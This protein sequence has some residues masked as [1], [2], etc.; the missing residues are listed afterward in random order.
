MAELATLRSS[1]R[2]VG[3]EY[4]IYKN[5]LVRFAA[6][7]LGLDIEELLTGPT[8]IALVG[9]RPDGTPATRS[10]WPRRCASSPATTTSW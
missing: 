7:E 5:T 1:L 9:D 8:A 10:G 2:E 3:G 6:R 4:R